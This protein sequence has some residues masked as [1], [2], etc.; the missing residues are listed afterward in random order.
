ME[1]DKYLGSGVF[2]LV[3]FI[4]F[5]IFAWKLWHGKWLNLIAGNNFVT[6]E[7]MNT[8]LQRALGRRVAI[9]MLCC[10]ASILVLGASTALRALVGPTV[11]MLPDALVGLAIAL[12]VIPC[13][14]V[15]VWSNKRAHEE[16]E[17]LVEADPSQA[18]NVRFERKQ[19][20]VGLVILI[21]VVAIY[22]SI[23]LLKAATS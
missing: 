23:P 7:E 20:L 21:G 10:C 5:A 15:V 12:I 18:D 16:Q 3:L 19:T 8:P 4:L 2:C 1:F 22:L 14:W 13:I 9:V 6:K 17:A 11:G